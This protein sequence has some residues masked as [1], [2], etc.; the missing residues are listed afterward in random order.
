M[1]VVSALQ[2][3]L[4]YHGSIVRFGKDVHGERPDPRFLFDKFQIQA[5]RRTQLVQ[6]FSQPRRKV[7]R[8]ITPD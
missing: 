8:F 7:P 2:L 5:Q 1:A 6:V 4:D 3:V